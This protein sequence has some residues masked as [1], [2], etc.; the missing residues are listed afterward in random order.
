MHRVA[1]VD[2]TAGRGR[3]HRRPPR[4]PAAG[5]LAVL[6]L[7]AG[8]LPPR[9]AEAAGSAAEPSAVWVSGLRGLTQVDVLAARVVRRASLPGEGH[10]VTVAADGTVATT[11][12]RSRAVALLGPGE[13]RARIVALGGSPHDVKASGGD[14]L[15]VAN[16]GASRLDLLGTDGVVRHS[17]PLRARPHDVAITRDGGTA[18]VSLNRTGDL[19]VVDLH[20]REVRYVATPI[21]P[22]D[23]LFADDGRLWVTD[24]RGHLAV[25][26]PDGGLE[27][28]LRLGREAHHLAFTPDGREVWVTDHRARRVFV[29]ETAT[30]RV[31]ASLTPGGAPHH[32]SVVGTRA[33]VAS[34]TTGTVAVFDVASRRLL[35]RVRVGPRPHGVWAAP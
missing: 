14:L 1:L 4:F 31:L 19:A 20:A 35:A 27:A 23:L 7:V 11:L 8:L 17:L 3:R 18:W 22:H 12:P 5:L 2:G 30:R 29:V 6:A 13:E 33:A 9:P 16:E 10:N 25:L 28:T 34:H 32:V 24:W 15:V 21:R 26:A